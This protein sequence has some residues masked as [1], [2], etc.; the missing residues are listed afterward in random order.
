MVMFVFRE[1]YYRAQPARE[2]TEEHRQWQ[3]DMEAV[4]GKAEVIVGKQRHGPTG[5]VTLQFSPEYTRFSNLAASE[6]LPE[7]ME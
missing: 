6:R 2:N 1:E 4:M 5:T 3:Q 7:R